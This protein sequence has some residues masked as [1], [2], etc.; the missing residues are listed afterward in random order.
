MTKRVARSFR[1]A[2]QGKGIGVCT[3]WGIGNLTRVFGDGL[4]IIFLFARE[5][6]FLIQSYFTDEILWS[7]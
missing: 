7:K 1:P 3:S 5:L 2:E 4:L 6:F